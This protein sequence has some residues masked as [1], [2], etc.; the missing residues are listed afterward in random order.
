LDYK[1]SKNLS[2]IKTPDNSSFYALWIT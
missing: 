1:W 2:E